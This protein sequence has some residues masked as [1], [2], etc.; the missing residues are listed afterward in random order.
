MLE[1]DEVSSNN[2]YISSN[3]NNN[4]S[5]IVANKNIRGYSYSCDVF[6]MSI[7]IWKLF[8]SPFLYFQIEGSSGSS[9]SIVS[10]KSPMQLLAEFNAVFENPFVGKDAQTAIALMKSETRPCIDHS[11]FPELIV[12]IVSMAWRFSPNERSSSEAI[13][14][15]LENNIL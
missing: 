12:E 9:N 1:C 8:C 3:S 14:L 10:P 15:Q 13:L 4:S 2:G 11:M 5:T 6:S 7:I